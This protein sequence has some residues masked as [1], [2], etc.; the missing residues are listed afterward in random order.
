MSDPH[1]S[2]EESFRERHPELY[3]YLVLLA[4]EYGVEGLRR[5]LD[6]IEEEQS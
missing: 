6:E 4:A 1:L 5:A 3:R 2:K